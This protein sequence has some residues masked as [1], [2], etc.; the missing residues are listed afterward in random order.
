MRKL[1]LWAPKQECAT[2]PGV[3]SPSMVSEFSQSLERMQEI[4]MAF[5]RAA[6]AVPGVAIVNPAFEPAAR[7]DDFEKITILTLSVAVKIPGVHLQ[8]RGAL[9]AS[10]TVARPAIVDARKEEE[11]V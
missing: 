6:L 5:L 10:Q 7:A 3:H 8:D 2:D 4:R 1:S 11:N 9:P